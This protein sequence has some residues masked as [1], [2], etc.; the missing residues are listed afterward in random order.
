MRGGF[1][2]TFKG[3]EPLIGVAYAGYLREFLHR[4]PGAVDYVEVPYELLRHDPT[5]F[6]I[7]AVKPL[8]LHC[9]SLS[10]AGSRRCNNR[11]LHEIKQWVDTTRTPW[12]GEHLAFVR[13]EKPKRVG[14]DALHA[15]NDEYEVGYTVSPSMNEATVQRVVQAYRTY[16]SHF[17]LEL[18]LENSPVYF[19]APGSTLS[20]SDFINE[21]CSRS[22]ARLLFDITHFYITSKHMGFD[23]HSELMSL[24]LERIREIHISGVDKQGGMYWDNHADRAPAIAYDL[25]EAILDKTRVTAVT[26][27]YNWSSTFPQSILLDELA[28]LRAVIRKATRK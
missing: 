15:R 8:V 16:S 27:E 12:I 4:H 18:L 10:I 22:S 24:P 26:L 23:P 6:Q 17:G 5:V 25:L 20:Q 28:R 14:D 13:A 1:Q 3:R 21:I 11:T 9:A 2:G 19:S 7:S